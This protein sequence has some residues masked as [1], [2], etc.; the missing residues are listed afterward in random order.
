MVLT[1]DQAQQVLDELSGRMAIAQV[2]NPLRYCA[3]LIERMRRGEFLPELGLKVGD[4]RQAEVAH[5]AEVVRIETIS[6]S[7]SRPELREIPIEF[8]ETME[9]IFQRSSAISKK[10]H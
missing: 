10:G 4:A 7:G 8:R 3:T 6:A 5:R 2:K 1:D 9:R